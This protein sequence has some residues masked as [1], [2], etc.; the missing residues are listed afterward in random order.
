[1]FFDYLGLGLPQ[2]CIRLIL[3]LDTL[4]TLINESSSKSN[5]IDVKAS[6][7]ISENDARIKEIKG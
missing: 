6:S 7:L 5:H 1:M 3:A 4:S 2:V